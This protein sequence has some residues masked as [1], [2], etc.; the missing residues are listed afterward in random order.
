[1]FIDEMRIKYESNIDTGVYSRGV[2]VLLKFSH[3]PVARQQ[4]C[5]PR[6]K[7]YMILQ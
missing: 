7:N 4:T 2:L 6:D 1:M 5:R 3:F